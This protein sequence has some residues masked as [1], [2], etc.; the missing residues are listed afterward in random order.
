MRGV[1]LP[2]LLEAD[3]GLLSYFGLDYDFALRARR[4]GQLFRLFG[5]GNPLAWEVCTWEGVTLSLR[6]LVICRAAALQDQPS[7][8][9]AL[10][11]TYQEVPTTPW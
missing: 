4:S 2:A 5:A 10:E 11:P 6:Q 9:C 7:A 1:N 3:R 8:H